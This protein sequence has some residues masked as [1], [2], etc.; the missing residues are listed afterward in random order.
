MDSINRLISILNKKAIRKLASEDLPSFE[1]AIKGKTFKNPNTGNDVQFG[2]LP[3]EEQKKIRAEY[4]KKVEELEGEGS[5]SE[6]GEDTPSWRKNKDK[7]LNEKAQKWVDSLESIDERDLDVEGLNRSLESLLDRDKTGRLKDLQEYFLNESEE[8]FVELDLPRDQVLELLKEVMAL[9]SEAGVEIAAYIEEISE[10]N[11]FYRNFDKVRSLNEKHDKEMEGMFKDL[12]SHIDLDNHED[13]HWSEFE[14]LEEAAGIRD[15]SD[16]SSA[17]YQALEVLGGDKIKKIL[18]SEKKF[19]ESH[20]KAIEEV[21][22]DYTTEDIEGYGESTDTDGRG[23]LSGLEKKLRTIL[24]KEKEDKDEKERAEML[25]KNKNKS[26]EDRDKEITS[27]TNKA[28]ELMKNPPSSSGDLI[29]QVRNMTIEVMDQFGLDHYK[30]VKDMDEG[31]LD[32][33]LDALDGLNKG[34]K[35]SYSKAQ[36]SK[37]EEHKVRIKELEE[38]KA[39]YAKDVDDAAAQLEEAKEDYRKSRSSAYAAAVESQWG[40]Y[41]YLSRKLSDIQ[42]QIDSLALPPEEEDMISTYGGRVSELRSEALKQKAEVSS[43]REYA[44]EAKKIE[45]EKKKMEEERNEK[46]KEYEGKLKALLSKAKGLK[47][48]KDMKPLYTEIGKIKGQLSNSDMMGSLTQQI[49]QVEDTLKEKTEELS[50]GGKLKSFL[51]LGKKASLWKTAGQVKDA[52]QDTLDEYLPNFLIAVGD[53]VEEMPFYD[54]LQG[55][56]FQTALRLAPT[57]AAKREVENFLEYLETK[58][59]TLAVNALTLRVR[60]LTNRGKHIEA[61]EALANF[62]GDPKLLDLVDQIPPVGRN[63]SGE[64][65]KAMTMVYKALKLRLSPIQYK[66]LT[67]AMR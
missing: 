38:A 62:V 58:M 61:L 44:E 45:E 31:D 18:D 21:K 46:I 20:K 54:A 6:G 67:R 19:R 63:F 15:I 50:F 40:L 17:S 4:D 7:K 25:K 37:K 27:I 35:E 1:E 11:A 56:D 3:A 8:D 60:Q 53:D 41:V 23:D 43:D 42:T 47:S 48:K 12:A 26:R 65:G 2:S 33:L 24:E 29:F 13:T 16:L 9:D 59:E 55:G 32:H 64:Y 10:D 14:V 57:R 28:R 39:P 34:I 51:G 22:R 49:H 30:D 66:A 5:K 52:L 36:K